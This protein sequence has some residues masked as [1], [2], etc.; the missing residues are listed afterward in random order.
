MP[1]FVP[2]L[3]GASVSKV[4]M[5]ASFFGTPDYRIR[6]SHLTVAPCCIDIPICMSESNGVNPEFIFTFF[7]LSR[8]GQQN[9]IS[10]RH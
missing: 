5:D 3:G 1:G 6:Q 7:Q 9:G 4:D 10:I 8:E 2:D